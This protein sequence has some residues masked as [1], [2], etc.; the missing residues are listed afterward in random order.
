MKVLVAVDEYSGKHILA[1]IQDRHWAKG[2]EFII[3]HVIEP[4]LPFSVPPS[5]WGERATMIELR[6]SMAKRFAEAVEKSV[7]TAL[8][9]VLLPE[10]V[11]HQEI[12][13]AADRLGCDLIII[14]SRSRSQWQQFM[15]GSVSHT[16]SMHAHCSVMIARERQQAPLSCEQRDAEEVVD[17]HTV[18]THN[19]SS[20]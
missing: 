4:P 20:G 18:S 9:S 3:I 6:K 13:H 12:L 8:I 5:Y 16:V 17:L 14:G 1:E 7:Q 19:Q 15:L 11:A 10:G 2:T